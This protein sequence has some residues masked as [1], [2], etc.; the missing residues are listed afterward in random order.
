MFPVQVCS[1]KIGSLGTPLYP[2]EVNGLDTTDR[3]TFTHVLRP[4]DVFIILDL[5]TIHEI[6]VLEVQILFENCKMWFNIHEN[7]YK[8]GNVRRAGSYDIPFMTLQE[9]ESGSNL[10]L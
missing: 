4:G 9:P 1:V 3:S 10:A 7:S 6:S 2:F 5:K 8:I